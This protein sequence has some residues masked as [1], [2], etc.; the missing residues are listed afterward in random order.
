MT[1]NTYPQAL[2][3]CENIISEFILFDAYYIQ[4]SIAKFLKT[5]VTNRVTFLFSMESIH[6]QNIK[7]KKYVR[8]L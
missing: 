1:M 7:T 8:A 6:I 3:V 5:A 4:N 2:F